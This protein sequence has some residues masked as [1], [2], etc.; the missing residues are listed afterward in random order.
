[1]FGKKKQGMVETAPAAAV[2]EKAKVIPADYHPVEYI[3][4]NIKDYQKQ[5]SSNEVDSLVELKKVQDSFDHVI[6]NNEELKEKLSEFSEVFEEVGR[7]A[8]E[9]AG[10]KD[11]IISS[12]ESAQEKMKTLKQGSTEVQEQFEDMEQIFTEF[13]DSVNKIEKSMKQIVGIANQTNILALN[14]S[15]EAA[16][17]GD[18]GKGFA[19]VAEEVKNL[20]NQIKRLVSEVGVYLDSAEKGTDALSQSIEA[21]QKAMEHS[22]VEVDDA[23]QTFDGIIET[24]HSVDTVQK[25]ISD[26][27][28]SAGKELNK[29]EHSLDAVERDYD[30]LLTH[31]NRASELGT[32]KSV[33][34]ENVDNMLSQIIPILKDM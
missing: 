18:A 14:A 21:S 12:V 27:A 6:Q 28:V 11:D 5:L 26:A 13:K 29:I 1:M 7:S 8:D 34:F 24:A 17:A 31:I 4:G 2:Q 10:V 32:S 22:V 15:I 3:V 20:A 25:N 19:V 16:R 9:F 33:M 23:Y 30:D